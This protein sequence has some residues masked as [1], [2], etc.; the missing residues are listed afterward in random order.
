VA[1]LRQRGCPLTPLQLAEPQAPPTKRAGTLLAPVSTYRLQ[2]HGGFTFADAARQTEYLAR[3]GVTDCYASPFLKAFPGSP[4]GYD[5]TDHSRLNP[6]LGTEKDFQKWTDALRAN[7]LGLT[8]DF[9]PNHMGADPKT[10]PYWRDVLENGPAAA[11]AWFFDVDWHAVKPELDGKILLP[12]LGDQYGLVLERGELRLAFANGALTLRYYDNEF[13]VSPRETPLV[14][15]GAAEELKKELGDDHPDAREFLSVLTALRHLPPVTETDPA[16]AAERHREKETARERLAR[17]AERSA[18]ARGR[19]EESVRKANG[20]PGDPASFDLLHALLEKQAYRLAYWR[21]AS[22]EINYRRFFDI[23]ALAGVRMEDERV[24]DAAHGLLLRLIAEG[25]V[26]GL[27]LDHVDGLYDPA[28]Y[29]KKL[30][31]AAGEALRRAPAPPRPAPAADADGAALP[32]YVV[33]EKILSGDEALPAGWAVHGTSGYEF[34]NQVNGLFVDGK[35]AAAFRKIYSRFTGRQAPFSIDRYVGK[36]L[37]TSTS[38]ASELNV[39][40]H[41]LNRLSEED[42]RTR[43]YTLDSL[44]DGLREIVACF[45]VYRTYVSAAGWGPADEAVIDTAIARARRRNPAVEPSVYDFIRGHLLP[46]APG[47]TASAEER[48]AAPLGAPYRE[49]GTMPSGIAV[50]ESRHGAYE[51]RLNFALKFQQYTGPVQAKGLED[52]AFYRYNALVSLNEVGGEPERFGRTVEEFHAENLRRRR[53]HPLTLLATS[54]HDTKRG[55]DARARV[56]VLSEMPEAWRR[57]L[58]AWNRINAVHKKTV[59]GVEAPDRNDEYLF[60]QTLL[61]AW[62]AAADDAPSPEFVARLRDYMGKAIKES[63]LHTSWINPNRAYDEAVASF[64]E[65]VLTGGRA[66][67]GGRR[68]ARFLSAFKPFARAV[69][70]RG[71]LNSLSQLTLKIAS[72]GVPDFYQGTELW[73]LSLVDPDNRR[74]VDFAARARL[75]NALAPVLRA[76]SPAAAAVLLRSWEDGR[77][78]MYLTAQGLRLRREHSDLFLRGEY[79]PLTVEGPRAAHIAAFARV[80]EGRAVVAVAPRLTAAL[81]RAGEECPL[82]AD[83]W[84]DARLPV[85]LADVL[86]RNVFTGETVAPQV[87]GK[88]PAL[89]VAEILKS[90]PAALLVAERP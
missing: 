45:P 1:A 33:I 25:R 14:L 27:R 16:R 39:L 77:I 67:G 49:S 7:G 47:P 22:H 26:T 12:V 46:V 66:P 68:A 54:T 13:P 86:Y 43:D 64:V 51:R 4:H 82:G 90:A 81:P 69:A 21:T 34:L 31:A 24:F 19:I 40:A 57:A 8:L 58:S 32:L 71:M 59:D 74:P 29:F 52:T 70:F 3:L 76:P 48:A 85:P 60:Y 84:G 75:L 38:M 62:P 65:N 36:R 6:D 37:I 79:L 9:V 55:E 44:R 18:A 78:K 80:L 53:D 28:A 41:A 89:A 23:N 72:P 17:L 50:P 15:D 56:N 35:N 61:A 63:K 10:N 87:M 30:Q 20:R 2:L 83:V 73:D 42:R 5:I 88:P 11:H